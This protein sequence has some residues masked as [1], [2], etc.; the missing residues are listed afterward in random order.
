MSKGLKKLNIISNARLIG[1]I[2]K[3]LQMKQLILHNLDMF[4]EDEDI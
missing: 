2:Q 4:K 3:T 1:W